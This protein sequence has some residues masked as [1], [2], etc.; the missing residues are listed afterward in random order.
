M[1]SF[2]KCYDKINKKI[3]PFRKDYCILIISWGSNRTVFCL[4][5]L[6]IVLDAACMNRPVFVRAV[7]A[8]TETL[9]IFFDSLPNLGRFFT[10][11]YIGK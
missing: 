5:F 2:R 7:P 9:K 6:V 10:P 3:I 1:S 8:K 4:F 11:P